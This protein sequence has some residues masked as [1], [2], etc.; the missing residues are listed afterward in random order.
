VPHNRPDGETKE[1]QMKRQYAFLLTPLL[2]LALLTGCGSD[3]GGTGIT[4]PSSEETTNKGGLEPEGNGGQN[5][6]QAGPAADDNDPGTD[7]SSASAEQ[8]S[9]SDQ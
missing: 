4:E 7:E 2:A 5:K 8:K 9:G 6:D 3:D 1:I